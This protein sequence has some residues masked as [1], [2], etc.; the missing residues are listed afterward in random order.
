MA[1][2]AHDHCLLSMACSLASKWQPAILQVGNLTQDS[3]YWGTPE[4]MT[5]ST[6]PRPAFN[7]SS[8]SGA[9]DLAGQMAG[10]F[11]S[12]AVVF[13][14]SDPAYHYT[15]ANAADEMYYAA[16]KNLGSFTDSFPYNCVS[17][18]AKQYIGKKASNNT[19]TTPNDFN[20]GSALVYYNS[21]SFYDD[22]F[23]ASGWMYWLTGEAPA[24]A[25]NFQPLP[26][27]ALLLTAPNAS[28]GTFV[29]T[30]YIPYI[31]L[32]E[33]EHKQSLLRSQL[34]SYAF[35]LIGRA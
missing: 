26:C 31:R 3:Q 12:A 8:A 1:K 30:V 33:S 15:L 4:N 9:S 28:T 18:F 16:S 32:D 23:W 13:K 6:F 5:A 17:Q 14:T 27:G 22:L 2:A 25:L 34:C 20:N 35:A 21:T 24:N 10:A 7:I 11:A 19:C 29:W